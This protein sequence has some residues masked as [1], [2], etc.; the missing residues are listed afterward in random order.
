MLHELFTTQEKSKHGIIN[1][2][3]AKNV[4]FIMKS[5][6]G[7]LHIKIWQNTLN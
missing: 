6:N 5:K 7:E 2:N 3:E 4:N 1:Q